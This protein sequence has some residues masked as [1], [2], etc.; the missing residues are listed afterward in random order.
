MGE[1]FYYF[2][3]RWQNFSYHVDY[4][5]GSLSYE[6]LSTET[7]VLAGDTPNVKDPKHFNRQRNNMVLNH[8][9]Y[10]RA[11]EKVFD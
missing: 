5:G 2:S 7:L 11:L 6:V 1:V 9:V 10:A 8:E 3:G 4:L